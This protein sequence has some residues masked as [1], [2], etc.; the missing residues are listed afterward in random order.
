MLIR[1]IDKKT[2]GHHCQTVFTLFLII[3]QLQTASYKFKLHLRSYWNRK[4]THLVFLVA[5]VGNAKVITFFIPTISLRKREMSNCKNLWFSSIYSSFW[6]FDTLI[7]PFD[8]LN[9]IGLMPSRCTKARRKVDNE[10]KPEFIAMVSSV[11]SV[12]W[13]SSLAWCMR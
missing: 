6:L 5:S 8:A 11:S 13:R 10:L 7:L 4:C 2:A 3:K 9:S 1:I 12:E